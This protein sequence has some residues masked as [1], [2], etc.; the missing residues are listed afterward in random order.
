MMADKKKAVLKITNG[1]VDGRNGNAM[2][3]MKK[4]MPDIENKKYKP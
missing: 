1:N 2:P 3:Y 4:I